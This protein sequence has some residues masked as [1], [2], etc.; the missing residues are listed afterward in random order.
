M[1]SGVKEA[2]GILG[3]VMA[4]CIEESMS[5][6]SS[7]EEGEDSIALSGDGWDVGSD[8][9]YESSEAGG[10]IIV[11]GGGGGVD[12]RAGVGT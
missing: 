12:S 5:I 8:A 4:S 1:K 10:I 3:D 7:G 11:G 9:V 2:A 6:L